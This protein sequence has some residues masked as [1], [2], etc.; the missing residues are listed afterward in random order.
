MRCF[1]GFCCCAPLLYSRG[2]GTRAGVLLSSGLSNLPICELSQLL[3]ARAHLNGN[4]PQRS[5][6]KVQPWSLFVIRTSNVVEF[7]QGPLLEFFD[8]LARRPRTKP[9]SKHGHESILA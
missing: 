1:T 6:A 5:P 9:H 3:A 2:S 7:V 8:R 4:I